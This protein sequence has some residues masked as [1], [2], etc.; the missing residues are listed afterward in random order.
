MRAI[1]VQPGLAESARLDDIPEPGPDDR[2]LLVRAL[3][4]GVCG[5]DREIVAAQHGSAPEG[6]TRLVLGHESLG[7]VVEAPP[8]SGFAPGD[9][10]VGIV[11]RPDPVPCPAC[12]AGEWDM[13]RNGRYTERGIRGRHGYGA[14]R[15]RLDPAFA[16]KVDPALGLEAVLLEPTSIVAKAWAHA[17]AIAERA[18]AARPRRL[19]VTGAGPIG[20]LAALLG[21]QRGL[22][23]HVFD[24]AEGGPKRALTTKLGGTYHHG[25]IGT[26]LAQ[27][28]PDILMECT[29][30]PAVIGA[31]LAHVGR[32]GII[33]LA[34]LSAAGH[35]EPLDIGFVN[36]TMVLQNQVLFGAVNANRAH[37]EAAAAALAAADR[38]W[39]AG[40]I[41][42]R[43]PLARF[44][45]ALE[46]RPDDIKVVIDFTDDHAAPH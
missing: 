20:L 18:S 19:L 21:R 11:R 9:H 45:E 30:A 13:C 39:L 8:A 32:N 35:D 26:V 46:N 34:G 37:Y 40:L 29:G 25:D 22:E 5:T 31:S 23:L 12:A 14:E 43:V 2:T 28:A 33:C 41:R 6:E 10:V 3:A 16:V 36:R 15:F 4:L 42:R 1:T 17:D 38:D 27:L 44:R 24:R 7:L